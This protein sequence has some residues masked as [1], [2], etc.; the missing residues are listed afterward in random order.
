MTPSLQS[1]I[2]SMVFI[3]LCYFICQNIFYT[4]VLTLSLL[5]N[6]WSFDVF[7]LESAVIG[8]LLKF[9]IIVLRSLLDCT[10]FE[11]HP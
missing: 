10:L 7:D 8:C 1:S 2:M 4:Y 3:I 5:V 9:D 11:H 6:E